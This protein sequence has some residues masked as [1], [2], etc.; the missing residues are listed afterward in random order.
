[1]FQLS[2]DAGTD[3]GCRRIMWFKKQILAT[4]AL[5]LHVLEKSGSLSETCSRKSA[6]LCSDD[7]GELGVGNELCNADLTILLHL[8][9][10]ESWSS[11]V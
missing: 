8:W 11:G 2:K 3:S 9:L 1:M 10:R 5:K 6:L 4:P 7:T